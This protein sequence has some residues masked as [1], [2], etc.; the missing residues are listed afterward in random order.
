MVRHQLQFECEISPSLMCLNTWTPLGSAASGGVGPGWR[1]PRE[2]SGALEHSSHTF[3]LC[4]HK[5]NLFVFVFV[6]KYNIYAHVAT[7]SSV[8]EPLPWERTASCSC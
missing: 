1:T 5:Y 2:G 6:Y 8:P 3:R 4:I 7:L